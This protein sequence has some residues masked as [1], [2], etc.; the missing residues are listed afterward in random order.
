MKFSQAP[1]CVLMIRPK[2]F[3]FNV[4]TASTNAFQQQELEQAESVQ[5]KALREF[6]AMVDL[7]RSN[8]VEV[9]VVEDTLEPQKPDAVFPNNWVSFHHDGTAILYPMFAGNRRAERTAPVLEALKPERVYDRVIDLTHYE[10]ENRFLEGTGSIVFD[11]EH[12]IAYAARSPRTDEHLVEEV[13]VKLGFMP[14]VFN[15]VDENGQPVYHT[16]V[17][18]CV[19]AKFAVLCLDAIQDDADQEKLLH[20]FERTNHQVIAISYDQMKLFAG[21]M[22]EVQA[23]T[24]EPLVLLSE[25]AYKSLLPGQLNALSKHADPVVIAIPTIEHFG[26]GSVRCMVAGVFKNQE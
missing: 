23:K 24:G 7:L 10:A 14:L 19:G 12:K 4:Q 18:M 2:A 1:D 5:E 3:G 20:S 22:I 6:D 25:K 16:N 13:C 15:A 11:Y 17:L 21:N 26:G 8:D 9:I